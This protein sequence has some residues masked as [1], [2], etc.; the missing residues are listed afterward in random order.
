MQAEAF[1][2][3]AKAFKNDIKQFEKDAKDQKSEIKSLNKELK[4]AH[5]EVASLKR[6]REGSLSSRHGRRVSELEGKIHSLS[7]EINDHKSEI[8]SQKRNVVRRDSTIRQLEEALQQKPKQNGRAS[9]GPSNALGRTTPEAPT[10]NPVSPRDAGLLVSE[11]RLQR[12]FKE[13]QEEITRLKEKLESYEVE[14]RHLFDENE[15]MKSAQEGS[16]QSTQSS[17]DAHQVE[18]TQLKEAKRNLELRLQSAELRLA[19]GGSL[20][21]RPT[22]GSETGTIRSQSSMSYLRPGELRLSAFDD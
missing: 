13:S 11:S 20:L 22:N 7:K 10:S 8:T 14:Y 18:I 9:P 17:A 21:R 6:E 16:S 1:K 3:D 2:L 15:R 4:A 5:D 12:E 19:T